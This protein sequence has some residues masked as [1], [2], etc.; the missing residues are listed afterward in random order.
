[1]TKRRK[2]HY[3]FG[4]TGPASI[5]LQRLAALYRP[6][7]EALLLRAKQLSPAPITL[8]IDIGAGP[9]HT[10]ALVAEATTAARTIGLE[11][12]PTFCEEARSRSAP[13]LEFIEHDVSTSALPCTQADL[14]FCRFL[15][16][17]LPEPVAALRLWRSALRSGGLLVLE[18]LERL[19]SSDPVLSRYYELIEGLQRHHGQRM[20]DGAH[21][22][23][24]LE[25]AGFEVL[26]SE[27]HQAGIS[28]AAMASLHR[29]NLENVR[30]DPWVL[31]HFEA[32]ILDELAEGLTRL[33]ARRDNRTP[34]DNSLRQIIARRP[35]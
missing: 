35:G 25:E 12:S 7:S 17:H 32:S 28:A 26:T 14:A 31:E 20:Y 10:T 13:G 19:R 3:S 11:R 23:G 15:L 29:P 24:Y 33:E 18:E 9:G 2:S 34:I 8:A 16:T 22:E 5:R 21:L 30:R 6:A 1:M 27:I 4:D